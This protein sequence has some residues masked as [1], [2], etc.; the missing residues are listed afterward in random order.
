MRT[1]NPAFASKVWDRVGHIATA[2]RMTVGG[3]ITKT[4]ALV[5]LTAFAAGSSW[6]VTLTGSEMVRP[7]LL[8]GLIGGLVLAVITVFRP[9]LARWTAPLYAVAEGIALG[10]ISAL[11]NMQYRGLPM[12]AVGLTLLTFVLMLTLYRT[13]V[14]RVTD[15][16]RSIIVGA[17][18]AIFLYYLIGFVISFFGMR[19]PLVHDS[20][21]LGIGFSA[22]VT[23]I[24]AF[25][26]LL[27]FDFIEKGVQE[28]YPRL[29]EWFAAFGV[30]VTL[31]WLYLE[32][33]RLLRKVRD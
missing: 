10:I 12:L 21:W 33:L 25:N 5:L 2:D 19:I 31:V 4:L 9:Q 18:G 3:T 1:S 17:T 26:L 22:V 7:A 8:I 20:G 27:D 32:I 6:Y 16:M 30:L 28:G 15:Q 11:Y 13:R 24:A 29:M 23:G 14:I